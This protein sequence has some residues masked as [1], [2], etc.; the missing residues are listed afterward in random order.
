MNEGAKKTRAARST[1]ALIVYRFIV[2][3][4]MI[5]MEKVNNCGEQK[6]S[7]KSSGKIVLFFQN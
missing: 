3:H 6:S 1:I 7:K 2:F 5:G 4:S